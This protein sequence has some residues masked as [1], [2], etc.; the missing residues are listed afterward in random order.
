MESHEINYKGEDLTVSGEYDAGS[1]GTY[2]T[3][4]LAASFWVKSVKIDE[5]EIIQN[6][7][8]EQLREIEEEVLLKIEEDESW[9]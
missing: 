5:T 6:L 1:Y 3:P 8:L 9:E 2:D 7:N 4:G